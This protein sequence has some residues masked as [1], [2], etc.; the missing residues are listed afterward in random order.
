MR[1]GTS[2]RVAAALACALLLLWGDC[3]AACAATDSETAGD[4]L[5]YALPAVTAGLV[6]GHR[7]AEGA[8]QFGKAFALTL[9]ATYLLKVGVDETRPNGGHLSFPSGHTSSAFSCAEFLRSRY[10]WRYGA[11]AYLAAAFV[12]YSRVESRNHYIHDVVAGAAIGMLSSSILTTR[13]LGWQVGLSARHD[14]L[15]VSFSRGW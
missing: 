3:R 12:G 6:A 14:A 8:L 2:R 1:S 15:G 9:G 11:P 13:L 10:G 5:Q 7:D 4:I